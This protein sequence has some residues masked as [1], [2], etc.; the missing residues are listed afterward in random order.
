MKH[1]QDSLL[2]IYACKMS[3][4]NPHCDK[5]VLSL[6]E[7]TSVFMCMDIYIAKTQRIHIVVY[8]LINQYLW[9]PQ[10]IG[11]CNLALVTEVFMKL[12]CLCKM[13][14]SNTLYWH[15]HLQSSI[16]KSKT[17]TQNMDEL[18]DN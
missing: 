6:C 3:A 10:N 8:I 13:S 4:N 15:N 7:Y 12:N 17:T 2:G 9:P 1:E 11:Y 5:I 18:Y 16:G 14:I